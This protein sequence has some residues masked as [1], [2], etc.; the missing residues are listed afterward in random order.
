MKIIPDDHLA[1][2]AYM[3]TVKMAVITNDRVWGEFAVKVAEDTPESE[4]HTNF[5]ESE[6]IETVTVKRSELFSYLENSM[7]E[8][9]LIDSKLFAYAAGLTD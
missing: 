7:K 5:D 8:G 6:D 9:V 1:A 2:A 4:R 3:H